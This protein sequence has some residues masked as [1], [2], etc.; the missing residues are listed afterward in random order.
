[1]RLDDT[2]VG[3]GST[4]LEVLVGEDTPSLPL[5]HSAIRL[6]PG[7]GTPTEVLAAAVMDAAVIASVAR[8]LMDRND[9][10]SDCQA[11]SIPTVR[12]RSAAPT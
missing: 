1:M 5:E 8:H 3:L 7:S 12:R 11:A 4:E 6:M 10:Q 9:K 2:E